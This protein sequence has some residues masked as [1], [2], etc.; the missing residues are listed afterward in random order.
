MENRLNSVINFDLH[1]HSYAS[2]YKE[3]EGIVDNSTKENLGTLFEKLNEHK[4]ALFSITDHNR[5]DVDLYLEAIKILKEQASRY[6][7]VKNIL[8]GVEF[9]VQ[10]ED[11]LDK[12]HIITI[13]DTNNEEEKLNKIASVIDDNKL[14]KENEKYS[15][16]DFEHI[17]EK[18]GLNVI[19]IACQRKDL[20]N[21]KGRES[22]LSDAVSDISQI[23]QVGYID[24]LEFNKPQVQGIL[25]NRLNKLNLPSALTLLSGSDCHDWEYYPKHD[26]NAKSVGF[27]HSK[28]K[29]LPTFK[30]L[31]MAITSPKTRFKNIETEEPCIQAIACGEKKIYLS[32]GINVI[33]GENGSGKTTL[34]ELLCEGNKKY[35]KDII[36]KNN[37]SI[38]KSLS[39]INIKYIPQ[40]YIV[41]KNTNLFR[42]EFGDNYL[43]VNN[44]LFIQEYE[45]FSDK[46]LEFLNKKIEL[47]N[48]K[49]SLKLS[50]LPYTNMENK[51]CFLVQVLNNRAVNN[52]NTHK[53]TYEEFKNLIETLKRINSKKNYEAYRKE[54]TNALSILEKIFLQI[55]DNFRKIEYE[56]K[57]QNIVYGS[58]KNYL[59]RIKDETTDEQQRLIEFR[60]KRNN[61]ITD[62]VEAMSKNAQKIELPNI[63]GP[64][65]G[66][67]QNYVKGFYF[68]TETNYNN[69]EMLPLFLSKMMT[70]DYSSIDSLNNIIT[71]QHLIK[72]IRNCSDKDKILKCWRENFHKFKEEACDS[73]CYISD[74]DNHSIGNT[75]GEMS[76]S[77][78]KYHTQDTK[79]WD[80]LSIDQPEDNISNKNI[81][82]HLIPYFNSI[83]SEKQLIFVTHNPLLVVNQD[84]DNVIF[85]E[86]YNGKLNIQYGCLEY[87]DEETNILELVADNMD[88]GK[89]TIA[90]R[91]KVYGKSH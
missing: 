22:S 81:K 16:Q 87:E 7:E 31:L 40:N 48:V 39:S 29:I 91:L 44:T 84:V 83:R 76:L 15:K 47:N 64:K 50:S 5:F 20:Y 88:G 59:L 12:C 86:S 51:N 37:M 72:A 28:A 63:P 34:L 36:K 52:K 24:A 1:I 35:A 58:I 79:E 68:N 60:T 18:I 25:N 62:L 70:T 54:L 45:E 56:I 9:D 53:E 33:I 46:L 65:K 42:D 13:F 49:N 73:M 30:G 77:Y 4:V 14:N 43:P 38:I 27:V 74:M 66:V 80:I 3:A 23:L 69:K 21:K 17:L 10:L 57:V 19:L 82:N 61:F 71:E 26:K 89:E 32:S 90:R 8:S 67:S 41:D 75:L 85:V 78:Y 6:P 11:D 2:K 55:E